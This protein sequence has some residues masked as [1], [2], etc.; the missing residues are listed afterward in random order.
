MFGFLLAEFFFG[1]GEF[2]LIVNIKFVFQDHA[3]SPCLP[4]SVF[5]KRL[6]VLSFAPD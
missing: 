6:V 1:F 2:N 4:I 5:F 3:L